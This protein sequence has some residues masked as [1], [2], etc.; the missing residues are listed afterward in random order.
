MK[1]PVNPRPDVGYYGVMPAKPSD[2]FASI[3]TASK[4]MWDNYRLA[5]RAELSVLRSLEFAL[6]Y[7]GIPDDPEADAFEDTFARAEAESE[8]THET[9]RKEG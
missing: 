4:L 5:R 6:F 7:K 2:L 3:S 1:Q 8:A 9:T